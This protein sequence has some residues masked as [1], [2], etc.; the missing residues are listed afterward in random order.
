MLCVT[1]AIVYSSLSSLTSSSTFAVEIGSSALVGSSRSSTSGFTATI[2]AMHSR[3]CW[4]PDRLSP[5]WSSLSLTSS[6]SA[7]LRS[8]HST[9]SCIAS[10]TRLSYRRTPNAMFSKIVIGNGVGFW[11]TIPTFARSRFTSC[12]GSRMLRPLKRISPTARWFG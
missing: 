4:P 3:C 10:P 8:A 5:L 9:R 7:A 6:H 2:R 11:N 1:M 12:D